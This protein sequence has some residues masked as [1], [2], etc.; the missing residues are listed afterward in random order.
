[1]YARFVGSVT[2][3]RNRRTFCWRHRPNESATVSSDQC[4]LLPP[5]PRGDATLRLQR[6]DVRCERLAPDQCY[7]TP[8]RGEGAVSTTL[9]LRDSAFEIVSAAGVVSSIGATENTAPERHGLLCIDRLVESRAGRPACLSTSLGTNGRTSWLGAAI[10]IQTDLAIS[11]SGRCPRRQSITTAPP[12]PARW[13]WTCPAPC[14]GAP[15][16]PPSRG[17]CPSCRMHRSRP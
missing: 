4:I 3:E 13:P 10:A 5:R 1:M 12:S 14:R 11:R 15:S 2:P 6:F 9:M 17:P 16:V 7:W 8:V